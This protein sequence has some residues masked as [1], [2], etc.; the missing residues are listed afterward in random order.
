LTGL[1]Q[2]IVTLKGTAEVVEALPGSLSLDR[3]SLWLSFDS[4]GIVT[5]SDAVWSSGAPINQNSCDAATGEFTCG[6]S[7][8]FLATAPFIG[9][10]TVNHELNLHGNAV[11]STVPEPA[12]VA[13]MAADLIPLVL[14]WPP[15]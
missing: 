2:S 14:V 3:S 13:L 12:S 11:L 8:S 1:E 4:K 7:D 15:P 9:P 6:W 5:G 10:T